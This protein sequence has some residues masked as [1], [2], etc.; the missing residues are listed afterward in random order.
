[1]NDKLGGHSIETLLANATD[2][3]SVEDH[4]P[5]FALLLDHTHHLIIINI[6]GTRMIPGGFA[7][8]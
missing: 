7:H 2:N 4:C 1:L 3:S 8:F 6:C 5:D